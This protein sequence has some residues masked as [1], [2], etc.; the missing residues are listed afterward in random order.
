MSIRLKILILFFVLVILSGGVATLIGRAVA[1]NI[2]KDEISERLTTNAQARSQHI[3]S[4]LESQKRQAEMI[5]SVGGIYKGAID[6]G[7]AKSSFSF[8]EK[9]A[10]NFLMGLAAPIPDTR[11]ILWVGSDGKVISASPSYL[12]GVDVSGSELF[13]Q[14]MKGAYIGEGYMEVPLAGFPLGLSLGATAPVFTKEKLDS[15]VIL[16]GGEK[17]LFGITTDTTG[18]GDTGEIYL[19]NKEGYMITPSRFDGNAVL[20]QKIDLND[21]MKHEGKGAVLTR[22]YL[23]EKVLCIS[24][25]LPD[26]GWT[27]VAQMS[28]H[29]AL[30][31]ISDMTRKM[32]WGLLI[33][34]AIGASLAIILSKNI[35]KPMLNLRKGAE[36]IVN[37][38]WDYDVST[39]AKDEVGELSRAFGR[40]TANLRMT[41]A[42]LREYSASLEEKV[43]TR[44]SELSMANEGLS[45][46]VAERKE[47]EVELEQSRNELEIRVYER[48][49]ELQEA[50]DLFR[51]E[52][53]ERTRAE[54]DKEK[55]N[56][57]LKTKNKELEQIVY[58]SS[59][60]LRS[61]LVNVQGFSKELDL[62][63]QELSTVLKYE[64]ISARTR[65]KLAP[66]VESD[67]PSS[68][69]YIHASVAKMDSLL[70]GL[71]R[72]SR[73]GRAALNITDMDM[74][75]LIS[76]IR[77]SFE[78]RIEQND[79]RLEIEML[80]S[81]RGDITSLNMVFSNLIDNAIKYRDPDKP[82][83]IK[84]TGNEVD[85]SVTYVVEDNG[86][87]IPETQQTKVFEIF[88][89]L[90]PSDG[91]GGE[92]L[93]L[94]IVTKILDRLEGNIKV[95]SNPGLGSRFIVTL[96]GIQNTQKVGVQ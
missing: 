78:Y 55:L 27:M 2:V 5:A 18:L 34:L 62:S 9:M 22:N 36:E 76:D 68:L 83:S 21:L 96:P 20:N 10:G 61:P 43:A 19:V 54:R 84:V 63:L 47:A 75:E 39:S 79:V 40:M 82:C 32:I 53:E 56:R 11:E 16:M 92:G 77:K 51:K 73:L 28:A 48:T 50:I 93:G 80:P 26:T 41:Q 29:E 1:T 7:L 45:K 4:M 13:Q 64:N 23:G 59:H 8:V 57:Q 95:E 33:V 60:D 74:N 81:C 88:H 17:T 90:D 52:L 14:G 42:E 71:L 37:G 35:S 38:N 6:S 58:V 30:S 65:E 31:P 67:I 49:Q 24:Q 94:T 46:E 72:L 85:G 12:I 69:S 87:G 89:R 86:I 3:D 66:I 70:S 44:T 91:A 15:V 25:P